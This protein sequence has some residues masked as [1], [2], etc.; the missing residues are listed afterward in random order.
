[1]LDELMKLIDTYAEIVKWRD[2]YKKF[3]YTQD[4]YK[5]HKRMAKECRNDVRKRII[6]TYNRNRGYPCLC[7]T[8]YRATAGD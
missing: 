6:A 5:E 4:E 2:F 8:P 3:D 7:E 1:M